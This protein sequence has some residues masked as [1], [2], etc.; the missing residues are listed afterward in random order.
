MMM[1]GEG[2]K[3]ERGES[4]RMFQYFSK[5]LQTL[6]QATAAESGYS[7]MEISVST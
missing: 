2:W 4:Q 3:G 5:A 6:Q 7:D 1:K